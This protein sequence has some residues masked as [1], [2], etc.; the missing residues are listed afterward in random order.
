MIDPM[1]GSRK[2]SQRGPTLTTFLVDEGEEDP[3]IILSYVIF[4]VVGTL[5]PVPLLDPLFTL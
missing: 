2:S 4:Q 5:T 1:R 3:N